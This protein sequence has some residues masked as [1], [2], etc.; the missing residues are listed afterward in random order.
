MTKKEAISRSMKYLYKVININEKE[1]AKI[2]DEKGLEVFK[3]VKEILNKDKEAYQ[4][5]KNMYEK[6]KF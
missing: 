1:L 6:E 3:V 2:K 5:L 4:I